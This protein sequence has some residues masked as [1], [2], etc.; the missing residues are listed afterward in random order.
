MVDCVG[1]NAPVTCSQVTRRVKLHVDDFRLLRER[2]VFARFLKA[3]LLD[4]EIWVVPAPPDGKEESD[5]M[6]PF[7]LTGDQHA[8]LRTNGTIAK[9][10]ETGLVEGIVCRAN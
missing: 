3:E 9:H 2:G 4:G 5:A 6:F 7:A 8:L 1:K 10:G